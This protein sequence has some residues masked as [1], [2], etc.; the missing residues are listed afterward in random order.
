MFI[1]FRAGRE[2]YGDNAVSYV[3]VK[4]DNDICV[5]KAKITPEHTF[6]IILTENKNKLDYTCYLLWTHF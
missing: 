6:S 1:Y 3:Q 4:H 2:Q 5:V